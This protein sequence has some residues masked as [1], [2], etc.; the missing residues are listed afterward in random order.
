LCGLNNFQKGITK[1]FQTEFQN[2][3]MKNHKVV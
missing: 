3:V 2:N 1:N